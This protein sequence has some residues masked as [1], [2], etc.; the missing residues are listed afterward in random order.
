MSEVGYIQFNPKDVLDVENY[1]LDKLMQQANKISKMNKI[2]LSVFKENF[3]VV[4]ENNSK[5]SIVLA[6]MFQF[7]LIEP[8]ID[9]LLGLDLPGL[10]SLR[11]PKNAVSFLNKML[12]NNPDKETIKTELKPI[13][14]KL[15]FINQINDADGIF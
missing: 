5:E 12:E 6:A 4:Y 14:D 9:K 13:T 2:I 7:N 1:N 3:P 8:C 15:N 10:F 11:T